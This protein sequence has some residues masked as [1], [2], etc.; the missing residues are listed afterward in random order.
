MFCRRGFAETSID[1]ICVAAGIAKGSFYRYFASKDD[2]FLAAAGSVAEAV[3]DA[4]RE[5]RGGES[6]LPVSV[7]VDEM[8]ESLRPYVPLLL[9]VAARALHGQ[10]A[11]AGV[12]PDVMRRVAELSAPSIAASHRSASATARRAVE[13]ALSR[14]LR[15]SLGVRLSLE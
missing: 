6:S 9:E 2:V 13:M 8:V 4:F 1:D 7:A 15:D 3:A 12:V 5:H 10:G 14:L 11:H